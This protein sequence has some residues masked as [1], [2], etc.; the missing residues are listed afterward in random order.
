M[1]ALLVG[2]PGPGQRLGERPGLRVGAVE[3]GDV[4]QPDLAVLVPVGPAAVEAVKRRP[5]QELVDGGRDPGR[6]GVLV[7]RLVQGDDARGTGP[8]G[9]RGP[10]GHQRGR[11]D[12]LPG[13]GHDA[14]VRA[15]V[16][17]QLH[18]GRAREVGREPAEDAHVG[19][20]ETVD[21]L[22][23]VTDRGQPGAV[24]ADQPEQLV[25][26]RVDV[27]VLVHADLGPAGAQA[28]GELRVRA[29]QRGGELDQAVE[30]D[31]LPGRQLAAQAGPT[32]RVGDQRAGV[33]VG[34]GELG[35]DLEQDGL[36]GDPELRR[37]PGRPG[38]LPQDP[39]AQAVERGHGGLDTIR[40]T[41]HGQPVLHLL[42]R[43]P[44]ERDG[45]EAGR[46]QAALRDLVR[47]PVGERAGLAAARS[48]DDQQRPVGGGGGPLIRV[49]AIEKRAGRR[50]PVGR[51]SRGVL[52]RSR[53][54]GRGAG[55][56]APFGIIGL[57]GGGRAVHREQGHAVQLVRP[58]QADRAVLAVVTRVPDDLAAAQPGDALA[59]QRP[60]GPAQVVERDV[61]QDAQLGSERG[62]QLA[63]RAGH[64]LAL[65]AGA[66]DLAHDLGQLDQVSEPGRAGRPVPGGPVGQFG[67]PVQ[68]ADGERLAAPRAAGVDAP[69]LLGFQP[70]V[71][72][73]VAVQ[74]VLALFGEELDGARQA[75]TGLQR[76]HHR[77]VVRLGVEDGGLAA[78]HRRGVR[79]GVADQAV[80][81][82]R[83]AP[84]VHRR[85]RGQ[86][87]LDRE[88][89]AGQV[90][91]AVPDRVETG[92]GAEHRE[93]RRPDVGRDEVAAG[94]AGQGDVQQ[95]AGV[96]PEDRP[97]VRGQV[98]DL[99]QRGGDPVRRL[100]VR[101]V[102]QVVHLAGAVVALVDGGDFHAELEPDRAR[103]AGRGVAAESLLEVRADPEQAGLGRDQGFLE[104]RR[105]GRMGEVA[106]AE[107]PQALA[108]RPPGQVLDVAVLAAGARELRV[109]MEVGVEHRG[110]D[111]ATPEGMLGA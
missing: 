108:Q 84:P 14:R 36:V 61:A 91:V 60:A 63:D 20:A 22:V 101:R 77:E 76:R 47:D 111:P 32:L 96:E 58:E 43:P 75:V 19:A 49:Q 7:G 3:H 88:D 48:R 10:A 80:P 40:G 69:G 4:G 52:I 78:E 102:Q 26:D 66:H 31:E 6:L 42:G 50:S 74:V 35:R 25:L 29:E 98:A 34:P 92:L 70:D 94:A 106:G 107:D 9:D 67:H 93:P 33:P 73:A 16:P 2:Q 71:A 23:R 13:G 105:P 51:R 109:D 64:L 24:A 54:A 62:H 82:Q 86:A 44:G 90:G 12:G 81:V 79:V 38:M 11:R 65:R 56:P 87:G 104:F 83:G 89:V 46:G 21:G 17:G 97:A 99:G 18:R 59:E 27:L 57:L 37:Q 95:V 68:H 72:L 110:S 15:V 103:A 1:R 39:Q 100:E 45:Q 30:V 41:E 85:V 5:A 8:G 28:G 55:K 53:R